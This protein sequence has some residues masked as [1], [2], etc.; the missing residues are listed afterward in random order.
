MAEFDEENS[1]GQE[2]PVTHEVRDRFGNIFR[3]GD[4]LNKGGQG[5]VWRTDDDGVAIKQPIV[6]DT[7]KL[8]LNPDLPIRYSRIRTLPLPKG[9]H[10]TTPMSILRDQ[11]G[12]VM[13]LL[14]GM[15]A[16]S[17]TYSFGGRDEKELESEAL[18]VWLAATERANRRYA[19][20]LLHYAKT[21][22][23]RARMEALSLSAAL[24]ARLH[25]K[26]LVY[27][28]VSSNNIFVGKNSDA[29]YDRLEA[30]LID[31][32]NLRLERRNGGG[33]TC[34]PRL[35]A[36][37]IVQ[38][39]AYCSPRTDSWSFAV[40]AFETLTLVHPFIGKMVLFGKD[41]T[42]DWAADPVPGDVSAK[43]LDEQAYEGLLPYMYDPTDPSNGFPGGGLPL[44]IVSSKIIQRLFLET[45][46]PGRLLP[47][48]RPLMAFWALEFARAHDLSL[49]CPVCGMS[50]FAK[51]NSQCPFCDC[52]RP[53]YMIARMR[54][55]D[56]ETV[57]FENG[58]PVC[59]LPH[60]LFHPFSLAHGAEVEFEATIDFAEGLARPARGSK[61]FPS[62]L[63][64]E[65][66]AGAKRGKELSK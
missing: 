63:E 39:R 7:G 59:P 2:I 20:K 9:I 56:W 12:Y 31:V 53:A 40:M 10:L 50:Y 5:V 44:E 65:F 6:R 29:G 58:F 46:G 42:D 61:S 16:L 55:R 45:L 4:E 28:D 14:D 33:W 25:L 17:K 8:D 51:E 3:L 64:F 19:L 1:R 15:K 60:R 57:L 22:G 32:D 34:T 48:R 11:P 13:R 35:G 26:G 43:P 62:E 36:P 47:H 24:L 30:W 54:G 41:E 52:P 38:E 27:G 37:E 21:G 18:P 66:V 49:N 23:A